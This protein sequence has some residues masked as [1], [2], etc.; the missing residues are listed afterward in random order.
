MKSPASCVAAPAFG[1][2][3]PPAK[4]VRRPTAGSA[5]HALHEIKE[6]GREGGPALLFLSVADGP[7]AWADFRGLADFRQLPVFQIE[8][9]RQLAA[10]ALQDGRAAAD[11]IAFLVVLE[12]LFANLEFVEAIL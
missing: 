3:R 8:R 1:R 2:K 9:R 11:L 10:P 5:E 7:R 6:E 4:R 12:I